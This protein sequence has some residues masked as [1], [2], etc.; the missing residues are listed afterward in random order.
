MAD[1][2]FWYDNFMEILY[3][4]YPKKKELTEALMDLL[5]MEREAVY[6]RLRNEVMF[7]AHEVV[8]IATAWNVSLDD[9]ITPGREQIPFKLQLW[10]YL[11]P[12]DR[13]LST[14]QSVIQGLDA[15]KVFPDMEYME[16]CN[17]LPRMLTSGFPYLSRLYLLKWMYLY[18]NEEASS[19]SKIFFHEKVTR[20]SQDLYKAAKNLPSVN[21]IFDN[22]L[23]YYTVSDV[24]YFHS[25]YLI[26]DEEKALIKQN[27]YDLLDYMSEVASKGCWPETGNKVSVYI[28][29]INIDTSYIYYYF[30]GE[31]KLC[32][33]QAFGKN[34]IYTED[35]SIAQDFRGW[36]QSKKRSSIQ[37]SEADEKSRIE[38]FARQ[39]LLVDE[40]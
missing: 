22:M 23:F 13:E 28:S 30:S 9:L 32:C 7:T 35:S 15:V 8:K 10:N 3:K 11:N 20:L 24:R 36:M 34:E 5:F 26:T 14:M 1:N 16:I 31:V 38:F 25:I 33:V 19:Y 40:L 18:V 12:S 17:K 6:R 4:K 29:H 37:I 21:F 2:E 39:R 27:L